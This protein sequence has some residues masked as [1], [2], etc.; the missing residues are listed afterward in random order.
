MLG[1]ACLEFH[2]LKHIEATK[3]IQMSKGFFAGI[4]VIPGFGNRNDSFVV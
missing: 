1:K 3:F 4:P 2:L